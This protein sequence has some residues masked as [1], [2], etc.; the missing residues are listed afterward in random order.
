MDLYFYL[1]ASTSK[2]YRESPFI[3]DVYIRVEYN[4]IYKNVGFVA[5]F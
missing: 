5:G 3:F 2:T 4:Y 1:E